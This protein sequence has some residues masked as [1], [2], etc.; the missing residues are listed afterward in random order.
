MTRSGDGSDVRSAERCQ[1]QESGSLLEVT[2]SWTEVAKGD[3]AENRRRSARNGEAERV[4]RRVVTQRRDR[5][6]WAMTSMTALSALR[7]CIC[8]WLISSRRRP[9]GAVPAG[10]AIPKKK[11]A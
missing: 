3:R 2:R 5:K 4:V 11:I 10:S 9:G 6:V 1:S 8:G 7:S